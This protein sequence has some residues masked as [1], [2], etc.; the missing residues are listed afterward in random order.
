[1]FL[2]SFSLIFFFLFFRCSREREVPPEYLLFPL[3]FIVRSSPLLPGYSTVCPLLPKAA[4]LFPFFPLRRT[5][6]S[7]TS[8]EI[9]FCLRYPSY[10][11]FLLSISSRPAFFRRKQAHRR[12]SSSLIFKPIPRSSPESSY[13]FFVPSK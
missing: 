2:L 12:F 6:P 8:Y 7:E 9:F 10:P 11:S 3:N 13:L 1:M 5:F 4:D